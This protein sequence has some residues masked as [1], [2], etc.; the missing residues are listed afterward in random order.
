MI[1]LYVV[2]HMSS[3]TL[4]S[5]P[6]QNPLLLPPSFPSSLLCPPF[7]LAILF[8]ASL[9]RSGPLGPVIIRKR[10]KEGSQP[11]PSGL[12][13]ELGLHTGDPGLQRFQYLFFFSH[14]RTCQHTGP[15][16]KHQGGA[17]AGS[18]WLS[19]INTYFINCQFSRGTNS[20][21]N[22]LLLPPLSTFILWPLHSTIQ[23]GNGRSRWL[24]ASH[25]IP[26]CTKHQS[27]HSR[28]CSSSAPWAAA[29]R[30]WMQAF[31]ASAVLHSCSCT[32]I[33]LSNA[34]GIINLSPC[35]FSAQPRGRCWPINQL[36]VEWEKSK[37]GIQ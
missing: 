6:E 22:P 15:D 14:H 33:F 25:I 28:A 16:M 37:K 3:R 11:S 34:E 30:R 5:P 32:G 4:D 13:K 36:S 21:G 23:E 24:A 18:S 8:Q 12:Q 10:R 7:P 27:E 26:S 31:P 35:Y 9:L 29:C 20:Q 17:K 2:S 19:F 1:T